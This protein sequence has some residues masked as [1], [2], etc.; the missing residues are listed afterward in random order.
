VEEEGALPSSQQLVIEPTE[1][2]YGLIKNTQL[3]WILFADLDN[4]R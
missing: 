3:K 1:S 4:T 2:W